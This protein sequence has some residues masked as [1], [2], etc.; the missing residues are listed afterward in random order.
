M[1]L[2][3]GRSERYV[4]A[5]EAACIA[6]VPIQNV[7]GFTCSRCCSVR[8]CVGKVVPHKRGASSSEGASSTR[9]KGGRRGK[10]AVNRNRFHTPGVWRCSSAVAVRTPARLHLSPHR[11]ASGQ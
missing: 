6:T 5:A 3:Q 8:P 10:D 9:R 2:L 4:T 11:L 1:I 7:R